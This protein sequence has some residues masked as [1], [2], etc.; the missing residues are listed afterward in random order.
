MRIS[1]VLLC[2]YYMSFRPIERLHVK[3]SATTISTSTTTT[4]TTKTTATTITTTTI[5]PCLWVCGHLLVR[6]YRDILV[7]AA[8]PQARLRP[9]TFRPPPKGDLIGPTNQ[10]AESISLIPSFCW[11][12]R[13]EKHEKDASA[14]PCNL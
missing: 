5:M 8:Q 6:C 7:R 4:T 10:S 13:R 9:P 1:C 3:T 11:R 14:L 12:A 2:S